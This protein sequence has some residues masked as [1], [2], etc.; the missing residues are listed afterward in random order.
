MSSVR[1]IIF[2]LGNILIGVLSFYAYI[3]LWVLISW[4]EP[5]RF[6]WLEALITIAFTSLIYSGFNFILLKNNPKAKQKWW[7]G[8]ILVLLT[9]VVIVLIVELS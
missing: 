4:G 7:T 5:F 2:Y 3:Y 1:K 9:Y 8:G 6:Q